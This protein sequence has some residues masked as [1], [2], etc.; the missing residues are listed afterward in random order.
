MD[1]NRGTTLV[2]LAATHRKTGWIGL[3]IGILCRAIGYGQSSPGAFPFNNSREDW[4]DRLWLPA[5]FLEAGMVLL[6]LGSALVVLTV[7]FEFLA[8]SRKA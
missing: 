5:T 7:F 4:L 6:I 3:G 1:D 2:E 8:L